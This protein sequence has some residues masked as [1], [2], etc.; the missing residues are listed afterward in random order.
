MITICFALAVLLP[1]SVLAASARGQETASATR[2][3]A[4]SELDALIAEF[5]GKGETKERSPAELDA[6]LRQVVEHLAAAMAAEK[7]EDRARSHASL[8]SVCNYAARPGAEVYRQALCRMICERVTNPAAPAVARVGMLRNLARVGAAECVPSL[9][10]L[11]RDQDPHIRELARRALEANP[12]SA[13]REALLERLGAESDPAGRVAILNAL[14]ARREAESFAAVAPYVESSDESVASAALAAL[15]QIGSREAIDRLT[16]ELSSADLRRRNQAAASLLRI[17]QSAGPTGDRIGICHSLRNASIDE[18]GRRAAL[19]VLAE[20]SPKD[21]VAPLREIV[22]KPTQPEVVALAAQLLRDCPDPAAGEALKDA[23]PTVSASQMPILLAALGDRGDRSFAADVAERLNHDDES[24]R[25]A[26]IRATALLGGPPQLAPLAAAAARLQGRERDAA[27]EALALLKG[28]AVDAAL[29]GAIDAAGGAA[30]AEL[31]RA[32]GARRTPG[33]AP[34]LLALALDASEPVRIA[35][36]ESLAVLGEPQH[37]QPVLDRLLAERSDA[38]RACAEDALVAVLERVEPKAQRAEI[39]IRRLALAE[40]DERVALI[41]LLG[42]VQTSAGLDTLR[43]LSLD[44]DEVV[45][46]AAIRALARWEDAAAL[47]DLARVLQAGA[48]E[49]QRAVVLRGYVRIVRQKSGWSDAESFE[50]LKAIVPHANSVDDR[51]TVLSAV[52]ELRNL[53]ALRFAVS[54]A[55]E[56]G[57]VRDEAALAAAA[58][59]RRTV[60]DDESETHVQLERLRG[61]TLGETTAR[62]L[63]ET[64]AFFEEHRGYIPVWQVA[65]PYLE[66]R[67][68]ADDVFEIVFDPEK[69]IVSGV[70]WKPLTVAAPDNPWMFDLT[71]YDSGQNRCVYLRTRV[72]SERE[73]A[74]R[75]EIGADDGLKVWLNGALVHAKMQVRPVKPREDIVPVTLKQG[76]NDLK[77]KLVQGAGGW[78]IICGV[79]DSE[80]KPLEGLKFSVQ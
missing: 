45:R 1:E 22:L 15:G 48:S 80:G 74:A 75:L 68:L 65:G 38:V 18:A 67:K 78:G 50:L 59:A 73:T 57:G 76:W 33:S 4:H 31:V 40:V 39:V 66:E 77:I 25:L 36:F 44:A 2:P 8:E 79:R 64:R 5:S 49:A 41:R 28:E 70:E 37:A 71:K 47:P 72:W 14:G 46:D 63:E 55:L 30:H 16:A 61:L 10:E 17:A 43:S 42:R 35:A 32:L 51:K 12:S 29:P 3:A 60:A 62:K 21:A 20:I 11:C 9:A 58:V 34:K 13:A 7:L 54:W 69:P 53:D 6:A 26:A 23:L 24:T 19:C 52:R 27:R 56:E